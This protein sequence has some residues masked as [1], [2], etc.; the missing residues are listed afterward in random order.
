MVDGA[1]LAVQ[2]PGART[3]SGQSGVPEGACHLSLVLGGPLY[4][5]YRRVKLTKPPLELV[6]R[7]IIILCLVCWFPLLLL[8]LV[9][10]AVFGGVALPLAYDLSAHIRFLVT[11]PLL[12][13]AE[14]IVRDRIPGIVQQFIE[15]K[16][17]ASEDQSRFE[18][19]VASAN[20]LRSSAII[21]VLL[22]LLAIGTF[23]T[24]RQNLPFTEST[25]YLVKTGSGTHLTGAG[26]YYAFVSLP[27]LRFLIMR[28]YF[29]LFIWYWFLWHLRRFPLNLSFLHPDRAGGLGFLSSSVF[30]FA[31]VLA[32]QTILLAGVVGNE[33]WHAGL[34]LP[35]FKMGIVAAVVFLMLLVLLPLTFFIGPL[36]EAG[37][38]GRREYGI[39]A[40]RYVEDFCRKWLTDP[41][42]QGP[43]LLGTPDIQSLADLGNANAVASTMRLVPISKEVVIRLAIILILPLLPLML[44][45]IKPEQVIDR[46]IKLMV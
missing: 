35:I 18:S 1:K 6:R 44:T 37:R 25:W 12:I 29:C 41:R 31:P 39:L 2:K 38:N 43:T 42:P 7:R 28:W 15:R 46:L 40:G 13:E 34:S 19:L 27:I 11:L 36:M 16:I 8:S 33:I 3:V 26:Y 24:W 17:I 32:A 4:E 22:L 23:W 45:M 30:A 9:G 21:E 14:V 10:H 20:R 5:L